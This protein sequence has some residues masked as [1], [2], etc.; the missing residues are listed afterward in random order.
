MSRRSALAVLAMIAVLVL[1]A[2][3]RADFGFVPDSTKVTALDSE[4][5][6]ATQAGSHPDSFTVEFELNQEGNGHTEG[7]EMRDV[8]VDLPPGFIGNPEAMQTCSRQ[9]FEGNTPRC[10][11]ASQVGVARAVVFGLGE[12][13]NPIY[14]VEPPP[15][16]PAQLGFSVFNW[17][18][19]QNASVRTDDGYGISVATPNLPVEI[20]AV[21]V[22]VWG[23]PAD[24]AHDP[25]R[26][27]ADGAGASVF[28]CPA[29]VPEEA[30]LTMPTSCGP[31]EMT[32]KADS[33]QNPDVYVPET[34]P[35]TGTSGTP[36]PIVGCESVPFEPTVFTTPT[37]SSADSPSGLGFELTLPN[38]GLVDP[39]I[40][41]SETEPEKTEVTLPPGITVN[42][43]AANGLGVCTRAQYGQAAC[44][45]VSKVGT[46]FAKTP[47]LKDPIEGS[48]YLAAPH[49][50]PFGSLI[51][52][53]LVARIPERGILVKQ[54][55]VVR[56]DPVTGQLTTT[57][58][59]LPPI[60]YSSFEVRLREGPRAPLITPQLCG[61]YTT[62]V[63]LYPFSNPAVAT[64][65][66]A[67]FKITGGAGGGGCAFS[68]ALLPNKPVLEAGTI[69]PLAGAYSPFVFNLSREDGSQRFAAL[70]TTLPKGLTAKLAGVP[71]C[72]EPQIAAATARN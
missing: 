53:Y 48:L 21:D 1:P 68:E 24:E 29:D 62:Q 72:P 33:K 4:G 36:E 7:G 30:F 41:H 19:V 70:E 71:Y 16:V 69:A 42:P 64:E 67:P 60:P 65:R 17:T 55:G 43:S 25:E 51:A 38:D 54:A 50:N 22:T 57:F 12:A 35:L 40:E 9:Q 37:V 59:H 6:P 14:N 27:C 44:P 26:V 13:I 10:P 52:L 66:T 23:T 63:K 45:E 61:T 11:G 32:V 34:V 3:A 46:L 56:A 39:E 8:I 18:P 47:L 20:S 2:T 49:E 15:G 5:R 58:D 28:G 31:F